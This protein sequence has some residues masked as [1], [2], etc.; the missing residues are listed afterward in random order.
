[1]ENSSVSQA[2]T[3]F[4]VIVNIKVED[5]NREE[6]RN[7]V[8]TQAEKSIARS[9]GCHRFEVCQGLKDSSEFALYEFYASAD[10][11]AGHLQTDHFRS[12]D[13]LTKGWIKSKQVSTYVL[14]SPNP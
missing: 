11:F 1:M 14:I 2:S 13:Q 7:A 5:K 9:P 3:M 8:L 6:F 10:H 4:V 12:F